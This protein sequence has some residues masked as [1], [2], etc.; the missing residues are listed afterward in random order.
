MVEF[1]TMKKVA[2]GAALMGALIATGQTPALRLPARPP[3]AESGRAFATRIAPLALAQREQA[4]IRAVLQGNVPSW[5][6]QLEPVSVPPR[7]SDNTNQLTVYAL[8]DYLAV[9]SDD[10]WLWVPMTPASAQQIADRL[11]CLLPTT[12]LVDLFHRAARARLSPV[13]LKPGA[14][15]TTVSYFERHTQTVRGEH[16]QNQPGSFRGL[17]A[18]H[19]KDVVI[20]NRLTN[21]P[22]RVAIYGW[23]RTNG[24]PIQPLYLGHTNTWVDYSHGVRLVA[25]QLQVNG[26][27]QLLEQLLQD[28]RWAPWLSDEG[29]MASVRYPAADRGERAQR[30]PLAVD[31]LWQWINL[32]KDVRILLS[33][34]GPAPRILANQKTRLVLYALPNGN[35]IEQTV[36]GR[37]QPGDDWRADLQQIG[38]QSRFLRQQEP[39]TRWI[40]AYLQAE[41]LAWPAWRRRHA[42]SSSRILK[43]VEGLQARYRDRP[44]R[45]VLSGHSGGGSF[46]F[47]YIN[48]QTNLPPAIERIAFLDANYAYD[49]SA[50][51]AEKLG[52]WLNGAPDRYLTVL[53]YHDSVALLDGKPFVSE[54]GGTW[55]RSHR[56]L[57]DLRQ[58]FPLVRTE[59]AKDNLIRHSG[60]DGRVQ[61]WLKENPERKIW[62]TIQ[63]ER[64][65]F[66]HA[67]V[68][69][70]AW[71]GK[72]YEYLGERAY[73][74]P[75]REPLGLR[76]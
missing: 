19:K 34:P 53:A 76:P 3:D 13:P 27:E 60:L 43:L 17:V 21:A 32:D 48:A 68:C 18:G 23:H 49:S 58:Y 59:L 52:Q 37:P 9:G 26:R 12:R 72:G 71:E 62:H 31:E 30:D 42:D 39:N 44:A 11:E 75:D 40:V 24:S 7:Q 47:G 4:I 8:P 10:D 15:M 51:H 36:G 66:I 45:L 56:M 14:E 1:P 33:E 6:R 74:V 41:G 50:G 25:N 16:P 70:T 54:T 20:A 55:G 65:G 57:D 69:G 38:A 5:L 29:V 22:G 63:V 64:N 67:L 2:T 73:S 61:F 28:D 46:I 35:T